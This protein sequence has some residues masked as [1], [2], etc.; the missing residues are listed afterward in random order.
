MVGHSPSIWRRSCASLPLPMPGVRAP[1]SDRG[2]PVWYGFRV[3]TAFTSVTR[4]Y[5]AP[6]HASSPPRGA[7]SRMKG[8]AATSALALLVAQVVA[9]HHDATVPADHLALVA[10]LLDARLD[11]HSPYSF[12]V[13]SAPAVEG[14][15]LVPI[16]DP[17]ATQVVGAQFHDD[18]VVREDPDVVHPH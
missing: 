1:A 2:S 5:F 16:D 11:L 14:D 18:P 17:P 3:E 8:R 6:S 9:D 4:D 15:L 10:D 13:R 12:R 7:D